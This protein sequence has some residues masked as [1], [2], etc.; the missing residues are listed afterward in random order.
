MARIFSTLSDI[1]AHGFDT[2]IDVRSPSE[3]AEDH[4]PGAI[5]LPALGDAERAEV[6]TIYV[7]DSPFKARKIGA[8]L[9]AQ[10]ASRHL[11]GALADKDGGW[12]PLVYCWRG[13]QRSGSFASIL[14]QIGWRAEVIDGG[15]RSYRRM[16]VEALYEAPFVPRVFLLDGST[17]SA[18]TEI[19]HAFA[20]MGGQI[21]DLEGLAHHRGSLFGGFCD[22]QPSQKAFE[23]ALAQVIAGLDPN[24]PVLIEAES[25]K[26]GER[27][28]PPSLWAAM[29]NAPRLRVSAPLAARGR[30][31]TSAYADLTAHPARLTGIIER[32]RPHYSAGRV[33]EWLEMAHHA[34]F[35]ALAMSLMEHH[36]DPRYRKSA[37]S[38][39][40]EVELRDLVARDIDDAAR[41]VFGY[42]KLVQ[43]E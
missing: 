35:E 41:A 30:Y 9:V 4:L 14:S 28:V 16:V 29:K 5:N 27:L 25:S 11:R 37:D 18:K 21:V 2:V 19:L 1:Y 12:R 17:G 8:A 38:S 10:N 3:F 23:G 43:S 32:L 24:L 40:F 33:S 6:G 22:P 26:V 36:Y 31:L 42:L 13:G 20:R 39:V 15:Y 34:Q 7:Q